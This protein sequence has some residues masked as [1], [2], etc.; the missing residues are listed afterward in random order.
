MKKYSKK[1]MFF[2]ALVVVTVGLTGCVKPYE[3][4]EFVRIEPS[5]TAFLI[6][7]V[8]NH[9][10]QSSF[11]S[12]ELLIER[13]VATKEIQI[14]HRWVK[15]G[16]MYWQGEWRD[17]ARV[18]IVE[19]KPVTREWTAENVTGTSSKNQGIKAESK[20]SISFSVSMN[21]SAQIDEANA[22]KFLYR[23]NNKSLEEVMDTEIRAMVE[24]RFVEEASSREMEEIL[25]EK[26]QIM[27]SVRQEVLAHF[28][29]RGITITVLGLKGDVVYDDPEIQKAINAKFT[30]EREKEAQT[31]KNAL[32]EEKAI[33]EKNV[34]ITKAEAKAEKIKIEAEAEADA[35]RMIQEQLAQNPEYIEY[36]KWTKWDGKLPNVMTGTD[37]SIIVDSRDQTDQTSTSQTTE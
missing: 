13:K 29:E 26:Q 35:V 8:G 30:A 9:T 24:S 10:E 12:E 5:Q 33:A 18:V 7:L 34:E 22:A 25:L 15:T 28:I 14:P 37:G 20:S 4:P 31:I 6:P 23:Y 19:R 27:D 36:I 1:I 11:E 21:C 32:N 2:L 17:N 16:R 3:K